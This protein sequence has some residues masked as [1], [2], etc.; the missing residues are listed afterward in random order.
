MRQRIA[1]VTPRVLLAGVLLLGIA[2]LITGVAQ[3]GDVHDAYQIEFGRTGHTCNQY[4]D[5][6]LSSDT[7]QPLDCTSLDTSFGAGV[8]F[9]GF[10]A[11]Q[12][13]EIAA[14]AKRLG[15]D[16][17]TGAEQQQIQGRVSQLAATVPKDKQ[18]Y[19]YSGLW[20]AGLAWTGGG[21]IA[22]GLL[23]FATLRRRLESLIAGTPAR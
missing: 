10:T 23:L 18:P 4:L 7:G 19:H 8:A 6:H 1:E 14:L 9:S 16:G 13:E 12:N 21:I 11:E 3:R 5:V 22:A 2:C 15:S 17:L 20:G